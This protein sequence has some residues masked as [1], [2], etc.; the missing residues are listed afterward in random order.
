MFALE[1]L[2][3][4]SV[5]YG[6]LQKSTPPKVNAERLVSYCRTTSAS[7]ARAR[8]FKGQGACCRPPFNGSEEFHQ[9]AKGRS[10]PRLSYVCHIRCR[11][12]SNYRLLRSVSGSSR[13]RETW[14]LQSTQAEPESQREP[15]VNMALPEWIRPP[16]IRTLDIKLT[17]FWSKFVNF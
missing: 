5:H 9:K 17:G 2:D 7:I 10:W 8:I 6:H 3:A 15:K 16:Q 13:G 1:R 4:R 11:L 14:L 12:S